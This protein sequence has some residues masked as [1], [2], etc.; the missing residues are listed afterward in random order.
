MIFMSIQVNIL[1]TN[2]N[3]ITLFFETEITCFGISYILY[4]NSEQLTI[5]II[6]QKKGMIW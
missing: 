4:E 3:A 5:N 2:K 1:Q 6:I